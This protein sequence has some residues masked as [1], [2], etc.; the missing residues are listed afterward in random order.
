MSKEIGEFSLKSTSWT[1]G[2]NELSANFEGTASGFG[3]VVGT[4]SGS[5]EPGAEF[6]RCS[7]RAGAFLENGDQM[8]AAGEGTWHSIGKHRWQIR[9]TIGISDGRTI[10]SDGVL[11]MPSRSFSGKIFD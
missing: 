6:G 1:M 5:G 4:L 11:D 8:Q 9:M 10:L 7:W 2:D 3:E